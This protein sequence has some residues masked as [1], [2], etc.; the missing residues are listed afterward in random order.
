MTTNATANYRRLRA[1]LMKRGMS[2]HGF[3]VDHG[4][5]PRTVYAAASGSRHGKLSLLILKK[6]EEVACG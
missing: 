2:L 4:Y 3:A 6:L 5:S 1:G